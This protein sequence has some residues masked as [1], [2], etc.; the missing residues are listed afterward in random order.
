[1]MKGLL[2]DSLRMGVLVLA[3][4]HIAPTS[5]VACIPATERGIFF[6]TA[7]T[8]IDA[9]VII[10][11][12]I[13][14][15]SQVGDAAG[16]QLIVMNARVDRVIKGPINSKTIR[17]FVG[18]GAC[19]RVGVGQ[20]IIIGELHNDPQRGVMLNAIEAA[21]LRNQSAEFRRRQEEVWNAIKSNPRAYTP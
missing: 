9:P 18:L 10:E 6:E 5:A 7:P 3:S 16:N 2:T 17:I 12:T 13:Y 20:G 14:D 4:W 19:T 15:K 11:A 21:P 8:D 1:M